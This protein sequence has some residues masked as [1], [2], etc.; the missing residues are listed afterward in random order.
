MIPIEV[1][2]LSDRYKR[3]LAARNDLAAN[4][5]N[6]QTIEKLRAL[7]TVLREDFPERPAKEDMVLARELL[8]ELI[9]DPEKIAD[10]SEAQVAILEDLVVN[11]GIVRA[12][13]RNYGIGCGANEE[14]NSFAREELVAWAMQH[15]DYFCVAMGTCS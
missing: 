1:E 13:L 2:E 9:G 14:D 12:L 8:G 4:R 15:R 3:L 10:W 6:D 7:M 5:D 11:I